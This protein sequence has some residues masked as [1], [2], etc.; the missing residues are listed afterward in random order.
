MVLGKRTRDLAFVYVC[1]ERSG[2]EI[3]TGYPMAECNM[4]TKKQRQFALNRCDASPDW[5]TMT[6]QFFFFVFLIILYSLYLEY[7]SPF[8]PSACGMA[9]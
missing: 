2:A 1:H 8:G 4:I 5:I 7:D 6:M 9:G 3:C